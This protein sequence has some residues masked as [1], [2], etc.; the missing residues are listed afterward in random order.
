MMSG[1]G[2]RDD[3]PAGDTLA[4]RRQPLGD[5]MRRLVV[6]S[7]TLLASCVAGSL[8]PPTALASGNRAA[9]VDVAVATL[10]A[11]AG[12]DRAVDEPSLANPVDLRSWLARM[13]VDE[14]RWLVGRL[15][16]QA[17]YGQRVTVLETRGAWA[18]VAVAGQPTRR[19]SLGYPGWMPV[20]QLT[21]DR[22]AR[23]ETHAVIRRRTAWLHTAGP[24]PQREIELASGTRLPVLADDADVWVTVATPTGERRLVRRA[25]VRLRRAGEAVPRPTGDGLVRTARRFVGA[26]YLWAGTSAFAFDC[27]GFTHTI[28]KAHGLVI[29]RDARDQANR[30]TAVPRARLKRGDL[31]FYARN[32]RV[33]HVAMYVGNGRM[34]EARRTGTAVKVVPVRTRGYS[35]ARRYL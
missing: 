8:G 20:A 15:E 29:P 1:L 2:E 17:L 7:M 6:V 31:V 24:I 19:S 23:A 3:G 4:V 30:G 33:H 26:P 34:I 16:T 32:G 14:R 27:S 25:H 9:F 18:R 28:Y 22:P 35:G 21:F 5:R 12:S 13:D 11:R 10:W